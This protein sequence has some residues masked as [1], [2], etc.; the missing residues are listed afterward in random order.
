M[1]HLRIRYPEFS[2]LMLQ[3]KPAIRLGVL[4]N[5]TPTWRAKNLQA[6]GQA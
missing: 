4:E 3:P 1:T 2:T 6:S 5:V